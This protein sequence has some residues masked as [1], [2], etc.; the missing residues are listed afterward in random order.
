MN[1]LK[2]PYVS[3]EIK[4][5]SILDNTEEMGYNVASIASNKVQSVY[6]DLK[7]GELKAD[8]PI[9]F[10][11]F[12]T[13]MDGKIAF[14]DAP[15]GPY[16]A[17]KNFLDPTGAKADFWVLNMLRANCDAIICGAGTLRSEPMFTG[18]VF[19]QELEDDRNNEKGN[20]IPWNVVVSLEGK[21]IPF[22]HVIFSIP[23]IPMMIATS[24]E[25]R[26]SVEHSVQRDYFVID[27]TNFDASSILLSIRQNSGKM[28]VI[29]TGKG[30]KTDAT[31]LLKTLK[32]FDIDKLLVESPTYTH[33][34][35]KEAL[36]DEIFINYSCLYL[37]GN[38]L[39]LGGHDEPFTSY[40]HPHTE[41]VSIHAH[42]RN[43]LYFRH[44]FVYGITE[45]TT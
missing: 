12:V 29:I 11:S 42:Q 43:F 14:K 1:L 15:E 33:F 23:E 37:G 20:R 39:S 17:Q 27:A 40:D 5:T 3:E 18:H 28:P 32:L 44:R 10:S 2:I 4:L 16:I 26:A 22:S 31:I 8:R 35:I 45:S 34:L 41:L 13:S 36:M 9:I 19:D 25:G 6:G 24:P 30:T 38:A 21:D 7:F